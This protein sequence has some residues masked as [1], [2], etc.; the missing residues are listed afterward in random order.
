[1]L[2][3]ALAIPLLLQPPAT[4]PGYSSDALRA[5]VTVASEPNARVPAMLASYTATV[6]TEAAMIGVDQRSREQTI[7]LEQVAQAVTW[8]RS[9]TVEQRVVGYRSQA[10]VMT[11]AT[12]LSLPS[13]IVPVLYGNRFGLLFGPAPAS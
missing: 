11:G 13:W 4:R 1:M 8:D 12:V 9:G 5:L 7:L 3:V 10:S 6:E 2:L